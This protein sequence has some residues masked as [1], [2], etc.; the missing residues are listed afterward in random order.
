MVTQGK[1]SLGS[2]NGSDL[3]SLTCGTLQAQWEER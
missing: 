2:V 1:R 3:K